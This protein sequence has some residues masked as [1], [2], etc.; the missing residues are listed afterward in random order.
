MRRLALTALRAQKP[1][2]QV[3]PSGV[4][5][6]PFSAAAGKAPEWFPGAESVF[7]QMPPL[8]TPG[9]KPARLFPIGLAGNGG[10]NIPGSQQI[11]ERR[12]GLRL[13]SQKF[14][15]FVPGDAGQQRGPFFPCSDIPTGQTPLILEFRAVLSLQRPS[16]ALTR[17]GPFGPGGRSGSA[18]WWLVRP[19]SGRG[20]GLAGLPRGTP[21]F[22]GRRRAEGLCRKGQPP[23]R[24]ARPG[25]RAGR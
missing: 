21:P 17:T 11:P 16:P 10:G 13:I 18:V 14:P 22:S 19:G 12:A 7:P 3:A 4:A 6:R 20:L 5:V 24:L 9:V 8:A 2:Y 15:G 23:S 1:R 25:P